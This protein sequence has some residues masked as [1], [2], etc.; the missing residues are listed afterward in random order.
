MEDTILKIK[1]ETRIYEDEKFAV[2][3]RDLIGEMAIERARELA[4]KEI[5]G[6]YESISDL[7]G[8]LNRV[9]FMYPVRGVNGKR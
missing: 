2:F 4:K 3:M 1:K 9:G 7:I 8:L 5:E 6:E